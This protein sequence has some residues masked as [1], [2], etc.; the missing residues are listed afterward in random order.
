MSEEMERI[1]I[2][3]EVT[4]AQAD[5]LRNL[6]AELDNEAEVSGFQKKFDE[7]RIGPAIGDKGVFISGKQVRV[8]NFIMGFGGEPQ[9]PVKD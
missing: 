6:A 5:Q 7:L 8:P 3:V 1:S 9:H 2:E 4:K